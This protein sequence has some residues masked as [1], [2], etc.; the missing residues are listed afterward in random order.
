MISLYVFTEKAN[1]SKNYRK[2]YVR[3]VLAA[4]VRGKEVL[5]SKAFNE[6]V[7]YYATNHI[8]I[9]S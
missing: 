6:E 2:Y 5:N 7:L 9:G 3:V 4:L 1:Y 8:L